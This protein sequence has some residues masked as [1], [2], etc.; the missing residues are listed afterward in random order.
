M[1]SDKTN[2]EDLLANESFIN[3]CTN[4]REEDVVYWTNFGRLGSAQHTLITNA[5]KEFQLLYT[6]LAVIDK[7][8]QTER[9]RNRINTDLAQVIKIDRAT[10][11]KNKWMFGIA[12]SAILVLALLLAPYF[13]KTP[14]PS[15]TLN[16]EILTDHGERKNIQLPDGTIVYLNAGSNLKL[17]AGYGIETRTVSLEG[18][19]FFDVKKDKKVPFI[20]QTATMDIKALGTSFDVK[21]YR[22]EKVTVTSLITGLIEVTLKENDNQV[23]L[24]HPNQ[25]V[26][27][28]HKKVALP[29]QRADTVKLYKPDG[30]TGIQAE[31]LQ[32]TDRGE[33]KEIAWKENKLVFED[34]TLEEIAVLLERWYGVTVVI[35]NDE[36]RGYRFTGSFEKEGVRKVL[37]FLKESKEFSFTI[38]TGEKTK[39]YLSK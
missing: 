25:K 22:E 37:N 28:E 31:K 4:A 35:E 7:N 18:E 1:Y 19:A 3:F 24:L 14:T 12:A 16:K 5:R 32:L 36:I 20:V 34:D 9:L 8:E 26:A 27:W 13:K 21:A 17:G 39:V 33:V 6:T 10:P 23:L 29:T 30:L 11:K 15:P 38:E 2:I